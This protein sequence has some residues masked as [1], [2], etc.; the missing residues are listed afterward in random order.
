MLL[1]TPSATEAEYDDVGLSLRRRE[2]APP[3]SHLSS[4]APAQLSSTALRSIPHVMPGAAHGTKSRTERLGE[5][6]AEDEDLLRSIIEGSTTPEQAKR[7][8]SKWLERHAT[9]AVDLI[10]DILIRAAESEAL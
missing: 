1:I 2:T 5:L 7:R 9:D 8:L 10:D 4:S 3:L 6:W